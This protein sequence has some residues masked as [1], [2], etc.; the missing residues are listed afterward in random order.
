[1][2]DRGKARII[3]EQCAPLTPE[4]SAAVQDLVLPP[5]GS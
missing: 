2:L 3:A 4:D 1:M 5:P